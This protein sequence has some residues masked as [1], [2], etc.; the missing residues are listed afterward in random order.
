LPLLQA[1]VG[2]Q[3]DV[4]RTGD[5]RVVPGEFFPHLL[6]DFAAVRRFQVIQERIDRVCLRVVV[7]SD[8][9]EADKAKIEAVSQDVLGPSVAFDVEKV[10]DIPLTAAGKH[11]VVVSLVSE[12]VPHEVASCG[13]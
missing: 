7:S 2:R 6:K 1:V 4:L 12:P 10:S 8:W 9:I 13:R 3:L 11:R 5:G